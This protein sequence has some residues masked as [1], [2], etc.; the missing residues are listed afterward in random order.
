MRAGTAHIP[1][2]GRQPPLRQLLEQPALAGQLQALGLSPAHELVDQP[3]VY[4]F[5]GT[6]S[7]G[8]T[9]S[10]C[11]TS[12]LVIDASSMI[13]SYTERFTVPTGAVPEE[14]AEP[15]W[16]GVGRHIARDGG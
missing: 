8:S 4:S 15:V 3:V 1:R 6:T 7:D 5:A 11:V 16:T 9:V 12:L 2:A 13:G 14:A 10:A